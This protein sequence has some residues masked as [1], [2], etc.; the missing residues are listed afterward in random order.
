MIIIN[1]VREKNQETIISIVDKQNRSEKKMMKSKL[2]ERI[3]FIFNNVMVF[4]V[5]GEQGPCER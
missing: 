5:R 2:I 1:Y 4:H 3:I